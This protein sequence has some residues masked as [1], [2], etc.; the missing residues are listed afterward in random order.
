MARIQ[1]LKENKRQLTEAQDA[2]QNIKTST[3]LV[4]AGIDNW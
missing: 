1:V 2:Q 4:L 3:S